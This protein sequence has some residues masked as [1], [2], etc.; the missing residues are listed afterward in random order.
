[1][2]HPDILKITGDYGIRKPIYIST[3]LALKHI[4]GQRLF[5]E[6]NPG[7]Y[8]RST[9]RTWLWKNRA[10]KYIEDAKLACPTLHM[11]NHI[12]SYF[13]LE[14]EIGFSIER[15]INNKLHSRFNK[16]HNSQC[17]DLPVSVITKQ[18]LPSMGIEIDRMDLREY[19]NTSILALQR[20]L[21]AVGKQ[22]KLVKK[23]KS[24]PRNNFGR[25]GRKTASE[26]LF[27]KWFGKNGTR[28]SKFS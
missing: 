21:N 26:R 25:D 17:D 23:H 9:V 19:T 8:H 18:Q 13:S 6:L 14:R 3:V 20:K 16:R 10:S 7:M 2:Q 4:R 24:V 15:W 12:H 27:E 11:T 28:I 5:E 22:H 1:M